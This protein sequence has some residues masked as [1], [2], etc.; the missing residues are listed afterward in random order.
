LYHSDFLYEI[1]H[2]DKE[3]FPQFDLSTDND[4]ILDL[5]LIKSFSPKQLAIE[6]VMNKVFVTYRY[7]VIIT[8][9]L[10]SLFKAKLCKMG[11]QIQS[12]GGTG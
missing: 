11:K 2:P 4:I 1:S 12:F 7:D 9:H 6:R 10:R 5:K 3:G 8:D